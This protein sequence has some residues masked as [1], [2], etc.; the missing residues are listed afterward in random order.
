MRS[1]IRCK[2]DIEE[3]YFI[4]TDCSEDLFSKNIFW[5]ASSPTINKPIIDRYKRDSKAVLRIGYTPNDELE[6]LEGKDTLEEIKCIDVEEMELDEYYN[7][8]RRFNT[9]LAEMGVSEEFKPK[10]YIFSD[11][12][13]EVFSVLFYI[14]K[15]M[16]DKFT[17]QSGYPEL[18]VKIGNLFYFTCL[19]S[20]IGVFEINFRRKLLDEFYDEAC[21]Y[22]S[23]AIEADEDKTYAYL[24]RGLLQLEKGKPRKATENFKSVLEI[25]PDKYAANIGIIQAYLEMG[26]FDEAET[27][28]NNLIEK[29]ESHE[30]VWYLKG[31]IARLKDRLDDA[32]QF[33]DRCLEININFEKALF[34]KCE[35]LL[36]MDMYSKANKSY[37]KF[38][39]N[40]K[41]DPKAWFA[42]S[43]ALYGMDKWG[44]AIQC[45]N[46]AISI[47]P[48]ITDAWV[49]KGD[50]LSERKRYDIAI[51]SYQNALKINPNHEKAKE[52]LEK[53][54][55]KLG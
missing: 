13:V 14:L 26:K 30:E 35:I 15:E 6:F 51:T 49:T 43:R 50:I 34:K 55:E 23:L 42:K 18:Y 11:N 21:R 28:L 1:C 20:D 47:D 25:E 4:C 12:D 32:L 33:Y 45:V 17:N 36:E 24:N 2:K 22:Y 38:L 19:K 46:K 27:K 53:A 40:N 44:G 39:R 5:I 3:L 48:Q 37:D 52:R 31:K 7:S 54:K 9:I 41:H 29:N 8:L 10:R 16:E